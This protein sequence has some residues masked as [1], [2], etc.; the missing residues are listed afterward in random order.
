[1]QA[2]EFHKVARLSLAALVLSGSSLVITAAAIAADLPPYYEDQQAVLERPPVRR[3]LG[4][5]E[6]YIAPP[7]EHRVI[8]RRVIEQGFVGGYEGPAL[9]P[10]R[11]LPIVPLEY[12][13]GYEGPALVP[14]RNLPIVSGQPLLPPPVYRERVV[15]ISAP[16]EECRVVV[17]KRIDAYGD[18]TTRR[19]RICD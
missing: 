19:T 9:V 3:R 8:G 4:V 2:F 1:M 12:S 5:E 15:G 10:Q 16:V 11:P 18:V 7:V 17:R 14:P 13:D 6:T